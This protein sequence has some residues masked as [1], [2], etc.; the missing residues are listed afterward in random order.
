[1]IFFVKL[2]DARNFSVSLFCFIA[3]SSVS[4]HTTLHYALLAPLLQYQHT[5]YFTHHIMRKMSQGLE[6]V[7]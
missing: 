3:N 4:L 5:Q 2:C 1:M 7:K 6:V